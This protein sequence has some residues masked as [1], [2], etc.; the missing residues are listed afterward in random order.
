M[1]NASL[2]LVDVHIVKAGGSNIFSLSY[3]GSKRG[4][5][6]TSLLRWLETLYNASL[7]IVDVYIIR[8]GRSYNFP[9][10]Y[11][12]SKRGGASNI[13]CSLLLCDV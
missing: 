5:V 6:L 9:L 11:G 1:Y 4:E 3:G 13:L 10:S 12:G 7:S 2:S 8:T